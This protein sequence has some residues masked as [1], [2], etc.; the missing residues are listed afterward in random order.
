MITL[1]KAKILYFV[2]CSFLLCLSMFQLCDKT[3]Q[4]RQSNVKVSSSSKR[5][6]QSKDFKSPDRPNSDV[7]QPSKNEPELGLNASLG[8]LYETEF[9]VTDLL[10]GI[11]SPTLDAPMFARNLRTRW[12]IPEYILRPWGLEKSIRIKDFKND[13]CF[14][15]PE[16]RGQWNMII[17]VKSWAINLGIRNSIRK[18]WGSVAAIDR[19]GIEVVFLIARSSTE[20]KQIESENEANGDVLQVNVK[21]DVDH[22]TIRTL[23]GMHW[24][25]DH[26]PG[27]FLFSSTDDNMMLDID[28]LTNVLTSFVR[29]A[30]GLQ[31]DATGCKPRHI[32]PILCGFSFRKHDKPNRTPGNAWSISVEEYP[33]TFLPPYCQGGLYTTSVSTVR[34]LVDVGTKTK[35]MSGLDA[36]WITGILRQKVGLEGEMLKDLVPEEDRTFLV[37]YIGKDIAQALEDRWESSQ[38][39]RL[40]KRKIYSR[41]F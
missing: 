26:L 4:Q 10:G 25:A 40:R 41:F 15:P 9:P 17:M 20:Q 1:K 33:P 36:A 12:E 14:R 39:H 34:L 30:A 27:N 19:I 11:K 3:E 24:A 23:A 16:P 7:N 6:A 31:A 37:R 29:G 35:I 28:H 2:A 38:L 13:G 22:F 32:F 8:G 5:P 21:E 18:T